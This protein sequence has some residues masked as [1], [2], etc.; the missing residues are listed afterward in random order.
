MTAGSPRTQIDGSERLLG[1]VADALVAAYPRRL[2]RIDAGKTLGVAGRT[3]CALA[4]CRPVG[5]DAWLAW[6]AALGLDPIN[7][8]AAGKSMPGF[9]R[10]EFM[11]WFFGAGVVGSRH[12][13]RWSVRQA[14]GRIGISAAT[15]SRVERGTVVSVAAVAAICR[16]Y[17][18]HPHLYCSPAPFA[19]PAR[20]DGVSRQTGTETHG[21]HSAFS[22][23]A[24]G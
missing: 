22:E 21:N 9:S 2:D 13:R 7:G 24:A 15:V 11:W 6:C 14:A 23:E 3:T 18:L 10:G 12:I 1:R 16:A 8:E 5:I 19:V 20:F 17:S 4:I